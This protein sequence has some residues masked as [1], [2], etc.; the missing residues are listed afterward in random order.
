[1]TFNGVQGFISQ[2]INLF[3]TT[4]VRTSVPTTVDKLKGKKAKVKIFLLQAVEAHRVV[5]GRGLHIS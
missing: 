2:K 1:L 4:A 5:R 3:I